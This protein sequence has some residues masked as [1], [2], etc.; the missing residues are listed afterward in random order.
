MN[1]HLLKIEIV[2]VLKEL[3]FLK[4]WLFM[5]KTVSSDLFSV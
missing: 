4:K 3:I 1:T 5:T 2:S